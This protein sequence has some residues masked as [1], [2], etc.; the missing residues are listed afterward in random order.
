V[1]MA[2][3]LSKTLASSITTRFIKFS[4]KGTCRS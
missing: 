3:N 2:E 1:E 4:D